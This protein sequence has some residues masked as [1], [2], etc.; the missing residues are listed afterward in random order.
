MVPELQ[1]LPAPTVSP[2]NPQYREDASQVA[3]AFNGIHHGA[4]TVREFA[5]LG[6]FAQV[7]QEL[8]ETTTPFAVAV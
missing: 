6:E 7:M 4:V 5:T 2:L 8:I 1:V 3:D